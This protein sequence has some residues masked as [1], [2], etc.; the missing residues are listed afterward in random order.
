[1]TV[2]VSSRKLPLNNIQGLSLGKPLLRRTP[3]PPWLTLT[4]RETQQARQR[5]RP[6]DRCRRP[7]SEPCVARHVEQV[8]DKASE[9]THDRGVILLP[10]AC[11]PM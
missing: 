5:H 7:S 4:K 10:I 2:R 11:E 8:P 3:N 9:A 1:V 6:G